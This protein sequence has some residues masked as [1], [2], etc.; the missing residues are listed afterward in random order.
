MAEAYIV[1]TDYGDVLVE[2][3]TEVANALD[4]DLLRLS[5]PTAQKG[6]EL[7]MEV[8]LRAFGAKMLE[9]IQSV[10]VGDIGASANMVEMM[11]KEKATSDLNRIERWAKEKL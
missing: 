9:I 11:V 2:V 4:N 7:G 1:K 3:N 5:E 10:G 8:P 6:K